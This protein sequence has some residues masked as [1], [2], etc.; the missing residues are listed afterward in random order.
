MCATLRALHFHVRLAGGEVAPLRPCVGHGATWAKSAIWTHSA[1]RQTKMEHGMHAT[2][3]VTLPCGTT[4]KTERTTRSCLFFFKIS[5][6]F[7]NQTTQHKKR[8][9]EW[10]KCVAVIEWVG[11]LILYQRNANFPAGVK[12]ALVAVCS[13]SCAEGLHRIG[14]GPSKFRSVS[15][16]SRKIISKKISFWGGG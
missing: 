15:H 11:V 4:R 7:E 14:C 10:P 2:T 3:N 13:A 6:I 1:S 12:P 8:S 5:H 16:T 9:R